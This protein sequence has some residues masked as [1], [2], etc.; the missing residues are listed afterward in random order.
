MVNLKSKILV[1][2]DVVFGIESGH[3]RSVEIA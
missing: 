3:I 1:A 2:F